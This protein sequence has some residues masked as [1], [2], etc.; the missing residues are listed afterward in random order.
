MVMSTAVNTEVVKK[1]YNIKAKIAKELQRFIPARKQTDFVNE[2]LE[3][4]LAELKKAEAKQKL[5]ATLEKM[6][7]NAKPF[8]LSSEEM[9]RNLR[10]ERINKGRYE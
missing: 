9:V 2:A 8:N 3:K 6:K 7:K 5:F 4:S 10:E 1:T